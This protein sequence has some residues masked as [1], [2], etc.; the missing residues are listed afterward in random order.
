M[1]MK[2]FF[3]GLA[4]IAGLSLMSNMS[5]P[6]DEKDAAKRMQEDMAKVKAAAAPGEQHTQ[7]AKLVGTWDQKFVKVGTNITGTGTVRYRSIL[8]GRFIVGETTATMNTGAGGMNGDGAAAMPWEG[9][10][11]LGYNNVTKQYEQ[12]HLDSMGTAICFATGTADASG[13]TITY[14][15]TVK[16]AITP[17]GR[18][19]KV[20]VRIESDD[21]QV[22][23]LWE[24][25]DGKPL[26]KSCEI[27]ETRQK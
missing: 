13:K 17:E 8:G 1:G 20:V 21:K 14:E 27:T 7:L 9:F 18:P 6:Q 25:R 22:I 16:D 23:E 10:C 12:T 11:T 15:T 26:A 4:V 24:A 19:F 3:S 2:L 5:T